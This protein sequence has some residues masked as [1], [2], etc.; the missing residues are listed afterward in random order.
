MLR[1]A[2]LFIALPVLT[3][4][5]WEAVPKAHAE[6]MSQIDALRQLAKSRAADSKCR[7][8]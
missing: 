8:L 7:I 3:L 5:L 4:P 1:L 2:K 6:T